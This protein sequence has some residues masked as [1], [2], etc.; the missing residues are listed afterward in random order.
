MIRL[1]QATITGYSL[2]QRAEYGME[3]AKEKVKKL[4]KWYINSSSLLIIET[5]FLGLHEFQLG[6]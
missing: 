3:T 5:L 2:K 4:M 1:L 6:K